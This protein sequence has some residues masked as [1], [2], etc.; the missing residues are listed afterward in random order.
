M[1]RM[2]SAALVALAG[3]LL[4]LVGTAQGA[5]LLIGGAILTPPEPDPF[6][7]VVVGFSVQPFVTG[8]GVGQFSGTLTTTVIL[9]DPSNPFANV[10]NPNPLLHGLTFV[11]Q[12]HNDASSTTSLGRMT[13]IDFTPF[14]SDV[15]YQP[16]AGLLPPTSTD[17][18]SS[19]ATLGWSFTGAPFG[20][21]KIT[22]G[23]TTTPLVAQTNA[24]GFIDV[25]AN[26]IDGS[27]VQVATFGPSPNPPQGG[28]PEPSA[29][30]LLLLGTFGL[31]W[32][33]RRW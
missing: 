16:G 5:P 28:F 11:Y 33:H 2:K 4:A 27:V 26:I 10:G 24:P 18:T 3:A 7:G 31:V 8:P 12:L 19:P 1:L 17:R 15:S 20:L 25:L 32:R 14:L 9:D 29:L 21:G 6:L 23:T 30:T 13:N 22:P